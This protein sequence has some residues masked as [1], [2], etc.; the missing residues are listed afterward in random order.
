MPVEGIPDPQ[1]D[2]LCRRC[3]K[4]FEPQEGSLVAPEVTGPL[5]A[6]RAA[7]ATVDGSLLR[8]Q[9]RRCTRIRR[10]TQ[11]VLWGTLLGLVTLILVLQKL[12]LIK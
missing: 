6:M 12:G 2:R 9:C 1:V 4:W 11:A 3:G 8:F 7:R 5:G 10:T